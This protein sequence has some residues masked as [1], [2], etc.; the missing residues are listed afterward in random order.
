VLA[1]VTGCGGGGGDGGGSGGGGSVP[2]PDPEFTIAVAGDIGQCNGGPAAASVAARTA[3][4]V[5]AQDVLVLTL[6]DTTY[7]VGAPVEFT[8]CFHPTWGAFKDRIRPAPG[9]HEYM[10]AGAEGYFG[11]FG[12][13]A[14][15]QRRGY[16]SFDHAGWHFISLNSNV[17]A[18]PG[19]AQYQWLA[20]DL[21][22]SRAALCTIAYWHYPLTSSGE[23]GNIPVMSKVYE[24][25]HAAGVDIVLSGHVHIYE[26]FAP[27][28]ADGTADPQ[29]GIRNFVVG[30]GGAPLYPLG[31]IHP[32]SEVRDN[33]THGILRLTLGRDAYH[34]AFVPVGGGPAR[35]SGGA[36]CHR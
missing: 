16:Y 31:T 33:T 4:L 25:L 19:S 27:Q 12:A 23:Y 2:T 29:N 28:A 5:G 26:R 17:D 20:A 11:Y 18:A 24:A 13:L 36:L 30:T 22:A 32:N 7:P 14:G 34:W 1:L 21:A 8:D 10:T 35:D 9:N 15:P 6:G 3:A